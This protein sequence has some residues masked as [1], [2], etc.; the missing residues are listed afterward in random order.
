MKTHKTIIAISGLAAMLAVT[1]CDNNGSQSQ[2]AQPSTDTSSAYQSAK[3]QT[4]EAVESVKNYTY[5]Q[6]EEFAQKIKTD[7]SKIKQQLDQ[8]STK[9]ESS[10]IKAKQ[11]AEA[12]MDALRDQFGK[13]DKKLDDVEDATESTWDDVK[14]GVQTG[15]D[16][17]KQSFQDLQ[18]WLDKQVAS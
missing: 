4:K 10:S 9:V 8:L 3:Q 5:A 16:Q 2:T 14:S 17:V 18:D 13:L 6:K 1:G 7:M 12:K 15:Y 11:E